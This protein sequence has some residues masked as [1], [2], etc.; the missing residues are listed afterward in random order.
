MTQQ[1]RVLLM[2]DHV[3]SPNA[4]T[5]QHL[6][7]LQN[8]LDSQRREQF[9]LVFSRM[10]CPSDA[11]PV[12]ATDLGQ[13]FGHGK[14]SWWKRFH[15]LIRYLCDNEIDLIH[16]FTPTDEILACYASLFARRK[17]GVRIPVVGQRRNIGYMLKTKYDLIRLMIRRFDVAYL[18]NSRDAVDAA[19]EKEGIAQERFTVIPNPIS[20]LRLQESR[21][22][23]ISR[24][25]L[26][27]NRDDFVI[28]MVAT[29]RRIKGYETLVRAAR[30]VVDRHP[31][32]RFLS[33][34]E[35]D[36]QDY[37]GEL[38]A[39]CR[40]LDLTEQF[41]WFGK[42]DNPYRVLPVFDLAVLSSYSESFSNSVLEYAAIGLPIVAS[43][44]GGMSEM[45]TDGETGFLVPPKQPDILAE[46]IN[47]LIDQPSLRRTFSESVAETVHRLFDESVIMQ[48]YVDFYES[49][50]DRGMPSQ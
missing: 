30:F 1:L 38:Q 36:D 32:V 13:V 29:V 50:Y 45:I 10:D 39:L 28:G 18:A 12:P 47:T 9:F 42:I 5:E 48:K 19:Y 33:I 17:R 14:F 41:T 31:N 37:L 16:A 46:K 21:T 7:W 49:R 22:S 8:N 27:F 20:Q 34:G 25:E 3:S 2:M 4:G 40:E 43:H 15:A 11:F 24:I 44:V 6:I 35:F 26:G 23:P